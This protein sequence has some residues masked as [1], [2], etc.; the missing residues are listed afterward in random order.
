MIT[1]PI[2]C[3][4]GY[5]IIWPGFCVARV[6]RRFNCGGTSG[7]WNQQVPEFYG[8][9]GLKIH[10]WAIYY[11]TDIDWW[12]FLMR[13]TTGH[14]QDANNQPDAD[15]RC[16][17]HSWGI[18]HSHNFGTLAPFPP[19]YLRTSAPFTLI[20]LEPLINITLTHWHLLYLL[21]WHIG[22]VGIFHPYYL[23]T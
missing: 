1:L 13:N 2:F 3:L 19:H 8:L 16:H 23:S 7:A 5:G 18:F 6:H 15:T 9:V 22:Q 20:S 4:L 12:V 17:V 10:E 11:I 14:Q 21:P